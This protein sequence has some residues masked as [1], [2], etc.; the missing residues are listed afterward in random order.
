[1]GYDRRWRWLCAAL[2]TAATMP[3]AEAESV[4]FSVTA[5][6][7]EAPSQS[8]GSRTS[9]RLLFTVVIPPRLEL[10]S[11]PVEDRKTA[12]QATTNLRTKV[13]K[14]IE[15]QGLTTVYTVAAP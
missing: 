14:T 6:G 9:A 1:M 3:A 8:A 10:L 7:A 13:L 5:S 4:M 11:E 2:A 15:T 12:W